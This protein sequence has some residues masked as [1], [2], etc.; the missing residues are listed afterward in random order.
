MLPVKQ[1]QTAQRVADRLVEEYTA[2]VSYST[3]FDCVAFRRPLV[4]DE[5]SLRSMVDL[6]S[7]AEGP[8]NRLLPNAGNGPVNLALGQRLGEQWPS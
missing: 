1:R 5:N 2:P 4:E 6:H 3:A 7:V 8:R